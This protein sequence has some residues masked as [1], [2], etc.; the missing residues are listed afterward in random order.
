M[1]IQTGLRIRADRRI[2]FTRLVFC[3]GSCCLPAQTALFPVLLLI[4]PLYIAVRQIS[5]SHVDDRFIINAAI[6]HELDCSGLLHDE[7]R[8]MS[9][10]LHGSGALNRGGHS[11]SNGFL[12]IV[13]DPAGKTD[14]A[15]YAAL[16][17]IDGQADNCP[18]R[19]FPFYCENSVC[20]R[21]GVNGLIAHPAAGHRPAMTHLLLWYGAYSHF[22]CFQP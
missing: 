19:L 11:E 6:F 1:R 7:I 20:Q 18:C 2:G 13:P 10:L 17:R 5:G 8:D 21:R 22:P 16:T 15:V 12:R 4:Y 9:A 3:A 14:K